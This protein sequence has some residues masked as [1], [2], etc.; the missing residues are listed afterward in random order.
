MNKVGGD[1]SRSK[2]LL[3]I[4]TQKYSKKICALNELI[5][6][7]ERQSKNTLYKYELNKNSKIM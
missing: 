6:K 4:Y 3:P 7:L 1:E 5:M 2:C